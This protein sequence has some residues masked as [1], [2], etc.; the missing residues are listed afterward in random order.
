M[1]EYD[2]WQRIK[3]KGHRNETVLAFIRLCHYSLLISKSFWQQTSPPLRYMSVPDKGTTAQ[4]W[5]SS[6]H[7]F[8]N[9]VPLSRPTQNPPTT[10]MSIRNNN[11]AEQ[12]VV[13]TKPRH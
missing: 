1:S 4:T 10:V 3:T 2:K 8:W 13:T 12:D 6:S 5:F 7:T 11:L 9:Y